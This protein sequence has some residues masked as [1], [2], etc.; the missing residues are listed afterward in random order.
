M[1]WFGLLITL[2]TGE[3]QVTTGSAYSAAGIL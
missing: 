3:L 2:P 1:F